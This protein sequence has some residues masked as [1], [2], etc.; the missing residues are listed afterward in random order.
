MT[1]LPGLY[2]FALV[3]GGGTVPPEL[4]TV[5]R[6]V[7]RGHRVT[8]LADDSMRGEVLATGATYRPWTAAPNQPSRRPEH[9]PSRDWECKTPFQLFDRILDRRFVGPAPGY[10]ADLLAAVAHERPDVVVSSFFAVGAMVGAEAAGLPFVVL[11]PNAYMLPAPGLPPFGLGLQPATGPLG[12]WR[13]R[14][15]NRFTGRLWAKGLPGLNQVRAA[16]GLPPLGSFFDQILRADRV[17]VLTSADF[18]FPGELPDHVRYVGPVLD[19]PA[20]AAAPWTAPPGDH[21]LVLVALRPPSR[22]TPAASSASSTPSARCPCGASSRPAPPSTRAP[23]PLPPTWRSS[24]LHPTRRCCVPPPPSSPTAG[25]A[26][27]CGP[28]RPTCRS[29]CSTTGA[30]RPTTPPASPPAAPASS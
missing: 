30:T 4:G 16:H 17:L 27:S 28:W 2:L 10:A 9:D 22:T 3:D 14:A 20:W 21:P 15:L 29:S 13:D 7:D 25:T 12:R 23:S 8:V 19:D 26:P 1:A 6:L 18:D 11:F 24:P 5:R